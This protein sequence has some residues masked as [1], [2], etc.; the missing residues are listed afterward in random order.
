MRTPEVF[1]L[2]AYSPRNSGDGLLVNLSLRA[3]RAAGIRVP[4][5]VVCLDKAAFA[6]YLD[7]N[8]VELVSLPQFVSR[9]VRRIGSVR[10]A[11]FFG[12]GG[13]YLRSGTL[14]EGWKALIA[15]G[16][17]I[18]GAAVGGRSSRTVYLP[19]SVGPFRGLSGFMLKALIRRHVDTIFL[20]DDKS[21]EELQHRKAV[22]T[23]DLVVLE[24]GKHLQIPVAALTTQERRK[25][26]FV[27]RDL[28][29]KPYSDVYLTNIKRLVELIPDTEFA[30]Q[31]SGRGNSDDVFYRRTFGVECRTSLRDIVRRRDAII[32]SVR[33]HG[34]LESVLAGV[35]SVHLSYERKGHAAYGDLGIDD[36]VF[37]AGDFDPQKVADVVERLRND[38]SPFWNSL[39]KASANRYDELVE[40]IKN[41]VQLFDHIADGRKLLARRN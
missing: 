29:G 17:Q 11:I 7:D 30:L 32:V 27:F 8:N 21:S 26:F 28:S 9:V 3:I 24:I 37:H 22:R 36:Y 25:V 1:L 18:A 5:T 39:D 31:S 34:S 23:G 35:P 41:E 40:Y 6:G 33:L 14:S 20:R 15:H 12:V 16:T 10:P 13:G 19:Q 4:I 2:H 38:P